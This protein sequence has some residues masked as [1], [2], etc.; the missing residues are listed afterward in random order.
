MQSYL[1]LPCDLEFD[2]AL[3]YVDSIPS[4]N[5]PSYFTVDLRLGWR[6]RE[7]LELSVTGMNLVEGRHPEFHNNF[8]PTG[9]TGLIERS[10][11]AKLL[12]EF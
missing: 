2:G 3:R 12:W 6:P 1:T 9:P 7:N 11:F 5:I 8:I 4:L 10:V